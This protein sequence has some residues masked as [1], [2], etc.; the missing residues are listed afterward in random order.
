MKTVID[1]ITET[2]G[3]S[4]SGGAT[5]HGVNQIK[6]YI[7]GNNSASMIFGFNGINSYIEK[8]YSEDVTDYD[9]LVLWVMS[10]RKGISAYRYASDFIY[11]IDFGGDEYY[12][13]TRDEFSW[14]KIDISNI[15]SISRLRITALHSN[16]DYLVLSYFIAVKNVFPLD[17][18]QG[19]KEQIEY[20]RDTFHTSNLIGTFS[21][22]EGNN[23]IEFPDHVPYIERYSVIKI[24]DGSNN[25]THIIKEEVANH[26]FYLG[27][28]Y[29][30]ELLLHDYTNANVY[31]LYA[32]E[33]GTTQKEIIL[34]GITVWGFAP[35]KETITNELDT[36]LE[37][38]DV[39]GTFHEKQVGSY[40]RWPLLIDC[41]C[42][43]SW[44]LLGD[45]S[46]I[47]RKF[48]SKKLVW[49]NGRKGYIDFDGSSIEM[50]PTEAFNI[51]P[52]VQYPAFTI[53]REDVYQ[54]ESLP[55]TST[56]DINVIILEQGEL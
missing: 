8:S 36:D 2:T 12:L 7:A 18:Y 4:A 29:D 5:V 30:G 39:S 49:I 46:N 43:D 50:Y 37:Q 6:E 40:F 54:G 47:V 1:N 26:K 31:L 15:N 41:E 17:I 52:K 28:L 53:V 44:E 9:E 24:D 16:S 14:I 51:V 27:E 45:I 11:K 10:V 34:P 32:V 3:W 25:E 20:E 23:Y 21:G 22:S 55:A 13:Y 48:L 35:E 38:V 56:L 19:I 33:F 42:K